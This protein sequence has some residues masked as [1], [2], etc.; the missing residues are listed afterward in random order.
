MI[1]S[2]AQQSIVDRVQAGGCLFF[3]PKDG[4]YAITERGRTLSI[5]QRPVEALLQAGWLMRDLTGHCVLAVENKPIT[6]APA[7]RFSAGQS[8]SWARVVRGELKGRA[9]AVVVSATGKQVRIMTGD[10]HHHVVK[11]SALTQ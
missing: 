7:A 9:P 5:D 1:L 8:V 4:R 2:K 10:G 11:P 3:N 6:E